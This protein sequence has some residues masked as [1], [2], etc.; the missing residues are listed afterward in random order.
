MAAKNS[1]KLRWP[2]LQIF[3]RGNDAEV[4]KA[5]KRFDKVLAAQANTKRIVYLGKEEIP[6]AESIEPVPFDEGTLFIDFT[7][8]PEIEAEGY[9]REVIRRIQQMRKDLK[10]NVEQFV[11][12]T[13]AAEPRLSGLL[14]TWKDHISSEV[15]AKT[16]SFVGEASGSDVKEWEFTGQK[17]VIGITP[18][19]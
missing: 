2:L 16:L 19:Q 6:S 8:T 7:V 1:S 12:C 13:I 14:E 18:I 17:V 5:V 4:N 15:R 9:A 3:V 11:D 10:L